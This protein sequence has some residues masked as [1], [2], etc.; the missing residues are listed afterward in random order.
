MALFQFQ[1]GSRL[2]FL[3]IG[4]IGVS[5][6]ARLAIG[7]GCRVSGSDTR[8]SQLTQAMESLGAVVHIGHDPRH[9]EGADAVVYSTA[10]PSDNV[11]LVA[12]REKG[13]PLVH[14]SEL[15]ASLLEGGRSIGVTGTHGKGT[16]SAMIA[17]ILRTAGHDAGFIIGGLLM[18]YGV[19]AIA[20]D[21]DLMVAE[22]DES[23]GSHR[24]IAVSMMV[25]NY[26]E[27]DHLNY[28]KD[29]DDILETMVA[30]IGANPRLKRLFLQTDCE[31]NRALR[32]RVSVDAT[33]Y[34][35]E[36]SPDYFGEIV[37]EVAFRTT[38]RVRERGTS[39]GEVSLNLPGSYNVQNALGAIAVAR[40]LG[41]EF[42]AIVEA[43]G[44]FKGL[45]NRFTCVQAGGRVLV[46]D[47]NSHPTAMRKVLRD[48]RKYSDG[49]LYVVFKPYRYTL[50]HYLRDEYPRAFEGAD[51]V[52]ITTM[53][54]ANEP[55][56][57]GVNTASFV[58]SLVDAGHPTTFLPEDDA[59][60]PWLR[61][62][63][64]AGDIVVFFGGDDFFARADGW[65]QEL[66]QATSGAE[67]LGA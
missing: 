23:D 47:Y 11:E 21:G 4:G 20:G 45:E 42:P 53:Y 63:T 44:S 27:A 65:A 66:G 31:G 14:R 3:G 48:V 54:A 67:H 12:A 32:E 52:L 2:H 41:V 10:I 43:L 16:V 55:P 50:M 29:F 26:L 38:F 28:Y 7:R 36:G 8:A 9:L 13:L 35:L 6:V 19:N 34:G 22:V 57:E 49:Q 17:H 64:S 59:I 51:R 1:P 56:I 33:S 39:L 60:I 61:E 30:T 25:C 24:N 62:N 46:K 40:H 18:D 15:L 37:E 58:Q 5:A